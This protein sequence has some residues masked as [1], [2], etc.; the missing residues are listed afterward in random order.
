MNTGRSLIKLLTI[1]L[2]I[3]YLALIPLSW[4]PFT[5]R[6]QA[7]ESAQFKGISNIAQT[8]FKFQRMSNISKDA[9]LDNLFQLAKESYERGNDV[10]AINYLTLYLTFRRDDTEALMLLAKAL[11]RYALRAPKGR[12][13]L[14]RKALESINQAIELSPT[15]EAYY[16]RA[17]IYQELNDIPNAT[18]SYEEAL[19]R[20]IP[21]RVDLALDAASF[22]LDIN[23]TQKA[24]S[25]IRRLKLTD[26]L[27][28]G[29][30]EYDIIRLLELSYKL[31]LDDKF[32]EFL[33][34]ALSK[35]P[36]SIEVKYYNM[37][38]EYNK[39]N[40]ALALSI[41]ED[42]RKVGRS[43]PHFLLTYADLLLKFN[44]LKEAE[45]VLNDL[46]DSAKRLPEY[47]VLVN[48]LQKRKLEELIKLIVVVAGLII[49]I[50]ISLV[51]YINI[52]IRR[53]EKLIESLSKY[54]EDQVS[55]VSNSLEALGHNLLNFY[56]RYLGVP[57]LALYVPSRRAN[58][59]E[60]THNTLKSLYKEDISNLT[61]TL[62]PL[63]AWAERHGS[64][65]A[66]LPQL[67]K[68][69]DF[70]NA[71][72]GRS[73]ALLGKYAFN[74]VLP[75]VTRGKLEGIIFGV[76]KNK[77]TL[78]KLV[79]RLRKE[80]DVWIEIGDKAAEDIRSIRLLEA[81]NI[82]ELTKLYNKR[83][84]LTKLEELLEEA[85]LKKMPLSIIMFDIDNFK[86]FNDK[87]G[88]QIGDEV[89]KAV[90]QM[91]KKYARAGIDIPFRYG[92]EELGMLLP[93]ADENFAFRIADMI[94]KAIAN[95]N[96]PSVPTRITVS[97]GVA[98]FP[99]HGSSPDD[100][101][102]EADEALYVSKRT[103]KNKVTI[104]GTAK[105]LE[106][107]SGTSTS[108][109]SNPEPSPTLGE[110]TSSISPEV[111][112]PK[113]SEKE[114]KLVISFPSLEKAKGSLAEGS[115]AKPSAPQKKSTFYE[116]VSD[117]LKEIDAL[118]S[119]I[120]IYNSFGMTDYYLIK[121]RAKT[122]DANLKAVRELVKYMNVTEFLVDI[123]QGTY[124]ALFEYRAR[125][126][127]ENILEKVNEALN[128][129]LSWEII[130]PDQ[131]SSVLDKLD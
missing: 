126:E 44:K 75:L 34:L 102:R 117:H 131:A 13:T 49:F 38:S 4:S 70:Y 89:L 111:Q 97:G 116:D 19:R 73:L 84:M 65:P 122:P 10:L 15:W 94:R 45:Q 79:N 93:G 72:A 22:F 77:K 64:A 109:S 96:F 53:R 12:T 54:Y 28:E 41:A 27:L 60:M 124:L 52:L 46:P 86:K 57:E 76:V 24:K 40:Y 105:V 82:D 37:L 125:D 71:F 1:A 101:F 21:L 14:L 115:S 67:K 66:T 55:K 2:V 113:I 18:S 114:D 120:S 121:I 25:I 127:I 42:L 88:H 43:D 6:A 123:G 99:T 51:I 56:K 62:G 74:L 36:N 9:D 69:K 61:V 50:S 47:E 7:I 3:S 112:E 129:E 130:P 118:K 85:K 108:S 90:G 68:D 104:A 8:S 33:E 26:D 5:L 16:L 20:C 83:Y 59:L 92:G 95:T 30:S 29:I 110:T 31:G 87:Y 81:S 91:I 63:S 23:Q 17:K 128:N 78:E 80:K 39:G 107:S 48:S 58:R 119:K 32:Q 103:G 106:T 11:Y 35:Y 98:T 100:L